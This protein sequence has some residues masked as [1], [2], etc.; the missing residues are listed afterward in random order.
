MNISSMIESINRIDS[1]TS[2][3]INKLDENTR[4]LFNKLLAEIE[5]FKKALIN[6]QFRQNASRAGYNTEYKAACR[7]L[8]NAARDDLHLAWKNEKGQVCACDGFTGIRLTEPKYALP[9]L[10]HQAIDLDAL[11]DKTISGIS[12]E[13]E[14]MPDYSALK[15]YF[16]TVTAE[17][18]AKHSSKTLSAIK[19]CHNGLLP[20]YYRFETNGAYV[21]VEYLL[22]AIE[23]VPDAK[24]FTTPSAFTPVYLKGENAEAIVL[25]VRVNADSEYSSRANA[26]SAALRSGTYFSTIPV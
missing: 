9:L 23:I 1:E 12:A 3:A 7:L 22:T 4:F 26:D 21:S 25:P 16:K 11:F 6:E 5:S 20:I 13:E 8:K 18:K 10:D 24:L 2:D 17:F 14:N 15:T 19:S